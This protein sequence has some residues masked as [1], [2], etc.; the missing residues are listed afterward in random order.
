M[1]RTSSQRHKSSAKTSF[2]ALVVSYFPSLREKV[3]PIPHARD[4]LVDLVIS[5]PPFFQPLFNPPSHLPSVQ[6]TRT[7]LFRLKLYDIIT[8]VCS[9]AHDGCVLRTGGRDSTLNASY[10]RTRES[11]YYLF[12]LFVAIH[13]GA[14]ERSVI[15]S[16]P[17]GH[18]V[19]EIG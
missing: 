10:T 3:A 5:R 4:Y 16:A 17:V 11:F 6:T 12:Y 19:G 14:L 13:S 7:H 15:A 2:L 8:S 1:P 9:V 18:G